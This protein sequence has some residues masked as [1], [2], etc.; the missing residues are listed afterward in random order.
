MIILSTLDG[1]LLGKVLREKRIPYIF[2]IRDYS[3][4]YV[5]FFKLMEKN[6]IKN[7]VFTTISSKGFYN[8]LP[9]YEYVI[10]HNFNK[11]EKKK[12]YIFKKREQPIKIVWNGVMRFFHYARRF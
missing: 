1:I 6:V 4:E 10:G 9:K 5:P 3:F 2:D 7:S 8:F 12:Q 11:N